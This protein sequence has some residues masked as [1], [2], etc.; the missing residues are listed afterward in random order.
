MNTI[1]P[2]LS[3]SQLNRQIRYWLEQE[4]GDITVLGEISN[5][6]RPSS[7]HLYFTLKDEGAQLRCVYFQNYH[8]KESLTLQN[9]QQVTAQGRLSLYE[10]R[11]EYQLIIQQLHQAGIGLLY[12]QFEALKKKLE[13]LGYFSP[14]RKK[15]LK[16]FPEVIAIISSESGAAIRD[17]LTT[18]KKRY[19]LAQIYVYPC[20]VQGKR[21][22]AQLIQ[23]I[24]KANSDCHADVIILARGGGS[25][26]D[27][28][29][30]NEEAL[31]LA[32]AASIIPIVAG[33]GHET[34][35]TIADFIADLRAATP[36]A[37]AMA[38]TPDSSEL[39]QN[40]EYLKD[41]MHLAVQAQLKKQAWL[42]KYQ[43]SLLF[44]PKHIIAHYWQTLDY[45]D[46]ALVQH[47]RQ[48][49]STRRQKLQEL[50]VYLKNQDPALLIEQYKLKH[51]FL[52][53]QLHQ[54]V[55][56]RWQSLH[57]RW[58]KYAHHLPAFSPYSTLKRGY[59]LAFHENQLIYNTSS[60]HRGDHINIRL[61]KGSLHCQVL[62]IREEDD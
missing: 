26:E 31:A 15:A 5:L 47:I 60:V 41:R 2:P 51:R 43:K 55:Y 12:E 45:R 37:A 28:W 19:A 34:D 10:A 22:T 1:A 53:Q 29:C 32:I 21:A 35:F 57:L 17:V 61:G 11:G 39:I 46:R 14:A 52:V 48:S 62:E 7:G 44:S 20:E 33:I 16:R 30:F 6:S 50:S 38:V 9:G 8:H 58:E 24:Q 3:I 13:A 18:L 59:A 23:A 49:M 54:A 4:I 42:L 36:T 56:K 25:I 40:I 27:L